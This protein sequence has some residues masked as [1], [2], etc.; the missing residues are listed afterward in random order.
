M[1]DNPKGPPSRNRAELLAHLRPWRASSRTELAR[2]TGLSAATVS[3]I[4]RDLVRRKVLTEVARAPAAAGGPAE[5]AAAKAGRPSRTLEINASCG[6]VLGVSLLAPLARILVLN[7]RGEVLEDVDVPLAWTRGVDGLLDPLKRAVR[8]AVRK[9][10]GGPAKLRGA[11][12]ALP[13]QFDKRAGI[14]LH[15]PRVP[16]WKDVPIRRLL[17]DWT[18]SPASIIGYAPA[19][20]LAEQ[21]R[22][23]L[24]A[25]RAGSA[26][27]EPTNLLCVEV[28]ENIAMG[29]IVNGTVLE[30]ISGNAG[31]LGHIT[32][33]PAGPVCYCG[34]RGCLE[35][36]ATCS[37]VV[38]EIRTSEAAKDRFRGRVTFEAVVRLARGGDAFAARLLGRSARTLGIGLASAVALFNPELLVLSGRFFEAGDLVLP[39]LRTSLHDY[40]IP[41]ATKRLTI[42]QSTLGATAPA[43]GAGL[44]AVQEVVRRL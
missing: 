20:A 33:D 16:E 37:S 23:P 26:A 34:S 8:T 10:P 28:A 27:G 19:I 15:Y 11:G 44:V 31:E 17:E 41:S 7:L 5:A 12:L 9:V 3:R 43:L 6:S 36:L 13:G 14:S 4:T 29:A 18:G 40:A 35:T 25:A 42:E 24:D 38:E 30:G 32:L 39:P 22:R 1:K 21:A 2:R